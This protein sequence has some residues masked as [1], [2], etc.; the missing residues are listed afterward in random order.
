MVNDVFRCKEPFVVFKNG[1]PDV[2]NDGHL[3]AGNDPILKTHRAYFEVQTLGSGLRV[4]T[5]T[6]E[7]GERRTRTVK[8]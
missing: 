7:P 3:V 2:Y 4:E 5:A 8:E 1:V 6:A